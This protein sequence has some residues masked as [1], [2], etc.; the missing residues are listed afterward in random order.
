MQ[1]ALVKNLKYL[2]AIGEQSL[3]IDISN[4]SHARFSLCQTVSQSSVNM[5]IL[6]KS[7]TTVLNN[8]KNANVFNPLK[9]WNCK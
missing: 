9:P 7:T 2:H 3:R 8:P 4:S 1:A 6:L 5:Y